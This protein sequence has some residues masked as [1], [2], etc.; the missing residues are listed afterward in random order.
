[1]QV[2]HDD[3]AN[4]ARVSE[5]LLRVA[6][7]K[8]EAFGGAVVLVDDRPPPLDHV[9]LDLNW[10]GS[11]GM[12]SDFERRPIETFSFLDRQFEHATEHGGYKLRVCGRVLLDQAQVLDRIEAFHD[13]DRAALADGKVHGSLGSRVIEGCRRQIDHVFAVLP[14]VAQEREQ[15]VKL[16]RRRVQQGTDNALG[17][18]RGARRVEHCHA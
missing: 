17:S 14:K 13:D 6:C 12:D 9:F 3:L 10:A 1:M 5:P 2:A 8:A 4:A 18:A 15:W 11:G 16:I 7:R